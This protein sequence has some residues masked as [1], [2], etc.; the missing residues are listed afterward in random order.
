MN[1]K[2]RNLFAAVP[3]P[4]SAGNPLAVAYSTRRGIMV[5]GY[6]EEVLSSPAARK[7]RGKVQLILTSPPFPL[8]R[9][10]KYGN[11]VGDEYVA[12]LKTFA[13]LFRDLLTPT[14]SIVLEMGNAWEPGQP[15]MATL[16]LRALL[17]FLE[18]GPFFLCQQFVCHNPTRLPGP[19]QWVTVERIRLKDAYTHIWWM[20]PNPRPDADNRRVLQPY[21]RAMI[22][23]LK[24]QKYNSGRRPS[25]HHIGSTSF[26]N[27]HNGSIPSNVLRFGNTRAND[28]YQRYCREKQLLP[29]PARMPLGL[30]EFFLRFLSR[31]RNLVLDPFAGSN[32]TGYAA[33]RLKRRWLAIE[34]REDYIQASK[35]RFQDFLLDAQL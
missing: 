1:L 11:K 28:P 3:L 20:S 31:P 4:D 19:A 21:S 12:W 22:Q 35:G 25:E 14:G 2:G 13:P 26:L 29:H 18:G 6:A 32:V 10:K 16:A 17:A 7:Y 5:N 15:T 27:D 34:A 24:R 23:L 30:A 8:N 9:K 33:E